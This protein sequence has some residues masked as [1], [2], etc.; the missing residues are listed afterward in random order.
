MFILIPVFMVCSAGMASQVPLQAS[1]DMLKENTEDI[2]AE[3]A[4]SSEQPTAQETNAAEEK[5]E[6]EKNADVRA[7]SAEAESF[8]LK[9]DHPDPNYRG[10]KVSL[11]EQDR[12]VLAHLV[13]GETGTEG[14]TGCA[15]LAQSVRDA[16]LHF[17]FETVEETIASMQ[18]SGWYAG[19][20]NQDVYDA[21]SYIFD[22]GKSAVQHR[23]LVMYAENACEGD[24]HETQNFVVQYGVVR[25]FDYWKA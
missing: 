21:I 8:L 4:V 7:V 25:Y 19:E 2:Q 3:S 23:I 1:E 12:K 14:F 17:G 9:I 20:A 24:W 5:Q 11:T 18:Y 10:E 6:K 13:M 15:L 16:M 22:Q